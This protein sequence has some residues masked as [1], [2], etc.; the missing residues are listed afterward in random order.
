MLFVVVATICAWFGRIPIG[1]GAALPLTQNAY[2]EGM[3]EG[4]PEYLL[5]MFD[6]FKVGIIPTVCLT[7]YTLFA[8]KLIPKTK[9]N[10]DAISTGAAAQRNEPTMSKKNELIIFAVFFAVMIAFFFSGQLG[11]TLYAIPAL[12]ILV[13]IYTGAL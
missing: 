3:V 4:H 11:N 8:W 5:N 2:Y 13:L 6:Y 10:A 7:L 1:M 12:G 9:I